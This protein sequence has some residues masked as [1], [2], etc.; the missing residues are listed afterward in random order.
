MPIHIGASGKAILAYLPEK[1]VDEILSSVTELP[2]DRTISDPN[3]LRRQL[4]EIRRKGYAITYGERESDTVG[5]ASPIFNLSSDVIGSLVISVPAYR[6]KAKMENRLC[7][8]TQEG[9]R[10]LSH[11]LGLDKNTYAEII[12]TRKE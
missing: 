1:E 12:R 2:K 10:D 4:L 8:L 9:A 5:I 3:Q 7:L 6:Y 11:L